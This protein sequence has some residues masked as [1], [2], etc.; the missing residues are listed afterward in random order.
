MAVL[1]LL[2][3][4]D[5]DIRSDKI[6]IDRKLT[7]LT[8]KIALYVMDMGM[9]GGCAQEQKCTLEHKG[10]S[11][12]NGRWFERNRF[13]FP[14]NIRA[15]VKLYLVCNFYNNDMSLPKAH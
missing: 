7:T 6:N 11:P 12:M 15:L 9:I 8:L 2:T 4:S 3:I 13:I 5:K 1:G 14:D 10:M